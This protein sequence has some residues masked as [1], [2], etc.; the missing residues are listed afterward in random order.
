MRA[1]L[2]SAGEV[3]ARTLSLGGFVSLVRPY[4]DFGSLRFRA[5]QHGINADDESLD[6]VLDFVAGALLRC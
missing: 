4:T 3:L 1:E 2:F 5:F 6:Q